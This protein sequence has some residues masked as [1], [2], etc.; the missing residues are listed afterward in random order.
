LEL[1][2]SFWEE[3]VTFSA[4][5]E[6]ANFTIGGISF[7]SRR[8]G[9]GLDNVRNFEVVLAN[10]S[11]SNVSYNSHPDLY[12]ALRGGGNQFGVVTRFDLET[13]AQG[14]I[15]GGHS[16]YFLGDIPER[17]KLMG[18]SN[19]FNW[20]PGWLV[21]TWSGWIQRTACRFG[22][23]SSVSQLLEKFDQFSRTKD[24]VGQ[25][26]LSF[27]FVPYN[28]NTWVACLSRLYGEPEPNPPV[29]KGFQSLDNQSFY[30]T[31]RIT[32]LSGIHA[33]VDWM[34]QVGYR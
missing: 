1:E 8:Y 4:R 2:A 12:F 30:D 16:Y 11:V 5:G 32:R 19:M 9:W 28:L 3:S 34:N 15:W 10:G 21:E 17:K 14:P 23:C 7:V 25:I 13:Y 22:L 29:F 31:N 18:V 33:E 26:I 24:P 6:V 20:T 27:A